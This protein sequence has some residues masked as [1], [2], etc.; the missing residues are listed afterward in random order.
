MKLIAIAAAGLTAIAAT[1]AGT[2]IAK[3]AADVT[4]TAIVK[5]HP[6]GGHGTPATWA[7]DTFKI[8]VKIHQTTPGNYSLTTSDTGSFTTVNTCA[9][10]SP[11]AG[12]AIKHQVT[13]QFSGTES[14]TAA[15]NLKSTAEIT[16][17]N[18]KTIDDA[19]TTTF[20][21]ET[22]FQQFFQGSVTGSPSSGHY[23]FKYKTLDEEYNETTETDTPNNPT[24]GDIT[25][26]LSSIL[27][28][29]GLCRGSNVAKWKVNNIQG[30]RARAFTY[31]VWVGH[32]TPTAH[33]NVAAN[34]SVTLKTVR[35][36]SL[37]MHWFNGYGAEVGASAK[38]GTAHC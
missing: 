30:G 23:A 28:P 37:T 25:G 5:N 6:D 3:A 15:G 33:G 10:C 20:H 8:T 21:S 29:V 17:L 22:W 4:V 11:N 34:S 14:G 35:G 27:Q 2:T 36:S 1:I 7:R 32:W 18:N 12:V 38:A 19:V 16:A 13:G 9:T 26:K 24:A 31:W